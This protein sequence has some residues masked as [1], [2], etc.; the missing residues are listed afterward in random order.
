MGR[1]VITVHLVTGPEN[2]GLS[3]PAGVY[4]VGYVTFCRTTEGNHQ[5]TLLTHL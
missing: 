2:S 4:P 3:L 1:R 5:A